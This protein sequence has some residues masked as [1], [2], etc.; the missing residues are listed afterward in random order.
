MTNGWNTDQ[1]KKHGV[2][3][4]EIDGEIEVCDSKT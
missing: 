3:I 4:A 2:I 1:K